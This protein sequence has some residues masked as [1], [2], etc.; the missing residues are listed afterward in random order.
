LSDCRRGRQCTTGLRRPQ[1]KGGEGPSR[2]RWPDP[3]PDHLA[4]SPQSG[5]TSANGP[6][7]AAAACLVC[8]G[9]KDLFEPLPLPTM[10]RGCRPL[11]PCD[12]PLPVLAHDHRVP[13]FVLLLVPIAP[14]VAPCS[15]AQSSASILSPAVPL[16]TYTRV[17]PAPDIRTL[18]QG[19]SLRPVRLAARHWA[20]HGADGTYS[21]SNRGPRTLSPGNAAEPDTSLRPSGARAS[22]SLAGFAGRSPVAP[23]QF[24][25]NGC[26]IS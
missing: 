8:A 13:Q 18:V 15:F 10:Q 19:V 14:P 21:L 12:P 22:R 26:G 16:D 24:A 20:R 2:S 17:L 23:L 7:T 9:R 3:S 4:A 5:Q 25:F 6:D 11:R 1:P